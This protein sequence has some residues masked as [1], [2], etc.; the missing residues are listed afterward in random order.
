MSIARPHPEPN[1]GLAPLPIAPP[2]PRRAERGKVLAYG[3]HPALG[4]PTLPVQG[5][6]AGKVLLRRE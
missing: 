1:L 4:N 6:G 3:H 5:G 2:T